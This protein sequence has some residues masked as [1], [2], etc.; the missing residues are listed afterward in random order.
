MGGDYLI[1]GVATGSELCVDD[2]V[3]EVVAEVATEVLATVVVVP[4]RVLVL[5]VVVVAVLDCPVEYPIWKVI[6]DGP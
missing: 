5:D 6:A 1:V 4:P 2:E 3:V